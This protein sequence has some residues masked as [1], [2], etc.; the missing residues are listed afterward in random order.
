MYEHCIKAASD[1]EAII[2]ESKQF[3]LHGDSTRPFHAV[4]AA[5]ALGGYHP[6]PL[7]ISAA[8]LRLQV[9][10]AQ[11]LPSTCKSFYSERI[12]I[13]MLNLAQIA[14]KIASQVKKVF[15][16]HDNTSFDQHI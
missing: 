13:N 14:E 15:N 1:F 10:L 3:S 11:N 4:P 12:L 2:F 16:I 6:K 5:A 8:P 9:T 7:F